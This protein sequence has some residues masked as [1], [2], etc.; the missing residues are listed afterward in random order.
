MQ[1]GKAQLQA[2][3]QPAI[4]F[5]KAYGVPMYIGEFSAIRW[6]PRER[7]PIS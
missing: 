6:C 4:D 3:L 5:Q 7:L 2:A 1:W